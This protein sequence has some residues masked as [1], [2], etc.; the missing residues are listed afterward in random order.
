MYCI[1]ITCTIK[2]ILCYFL[3]LLIYIQ[4][5][6]GPTIYCSE[7]PKSNLWK[8][9]ADKENSKSEHGVL[10][11]PNFKEWKC[12]VFEDCSTSL[13][14][15][16]LTS[17]QESYVTSSIFLFAKWKIANWKRYQ[18]APESTTWKPKVS[19]PSNI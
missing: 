12:C 14:N 9:L 5:I 8:R 6:V 17:P 11:F 19:S 1:C 7:V 16:P 15:E 2:R 18:N 10:Q 3:L 4:Q 13:Q